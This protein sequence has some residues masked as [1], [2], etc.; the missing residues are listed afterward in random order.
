MYLESEICVHIFLSE[1]NFGQYLT[2][3][4]PFLR[5]I[6]SDLEKS[7][8]KNDRYNISIVFDT[9]CLKNIATYIHRIRKRLTEIRWI[10]NDERVY[11]K[12]ARAEGR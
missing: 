7:I 6:I 3:L 1:M 8:I 11:S 2:E 4:P 9:I 12:S 5:R 10:R